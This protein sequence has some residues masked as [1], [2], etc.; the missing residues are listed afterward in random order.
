MLP[1]QKPD[2]MILDMDETILD[3]SDILRKSFKAAFSD[4]SRKQYGSLGAKLAD[5]GKQ[6]HHIDTRWR[7]LREWA[8]DHHPGLRPLLRDL[9]DDFDEAV[10]AK[11]NPMLYPGAKEFLEE[12][13]RQGIDLHLV[14]RARPDWFRRNVETHGLAA[15]FTSLRSIREE[16]VLLEKQDA[17][18]E[19]INAQAALLGRAPN[20][21]I[22][23]D[24]VGDYPDQNFMEKS[25]KGT[26]ISLIA[27]TK[28]CQAFNFLSHGGQREAFVIDNYI[29]AKD[30]LKH[31]TP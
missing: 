17:Y 10:S 22:I 11:S 5:L 1:K 15:L 6:H 21:W 25:L 31:F 23:G 9:P 19:I 14:T 3:L 26:D 2:A 29:E 16:P 4:A 12:A 28:T 24:N 8:F 20:I 18:R 13:S 7:L 30:Q 27:V